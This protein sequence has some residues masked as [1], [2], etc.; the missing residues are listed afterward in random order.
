MSDRWALIDA[1]DN[2]W[3]DGP[4]D[5][6]PIPDAGQYVVRVPPDYPDGCTWRSR[7]EFFDSGFHDVVHVEPPEDMLGASPETVLDALLTH[8]VNV[9]VITSGAADT[10]RT[11]IVP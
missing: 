2:S 6:E 5:E 7:P 9:S 1:T 10:I 8:L 11:G 3:I 4:L